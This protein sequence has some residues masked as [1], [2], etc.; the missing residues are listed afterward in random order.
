MKILLFGGR[1]FMGQQFLSVYPDAIA[2]SVDIADAPAV[3]RTLDEVKPDIVI[4]AAGKTGKPNVDWCEDH[5]IETIR[6]NVT[7]PLVLLEECGKRNLYWVHLSSGCVYS[8]DNGGR[9]FTEDDPP[10]FYGSF[11]S[12]TKAW[13]EALLREFPVL[14]LRLRMPFD[15]APHA[16]NL[17]MKLKDYSR[18]LDAEN[19]ITYLP[20]FLK[21]A[22]QLIAKRRTGIYNM[23][24]AG[25]ISPYRIMELYREI[26][27]PAHTF[28]RLSLKDLSGVT[29][30]GRSSCIISPAKLM[31]EG[32]AVRPVEEA[33]REA[34]LALRHS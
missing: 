27:D 5:K 34:L 1:G 7:G 6:S 10:N 3:I 31:K 2:P 28:E 21:A 18:I 11:Y 13:S 15:K 20:D 4:N 16:R 9:G 22:E 25:A 32:I 8:G 33:V 29:K 17:I 12:R 14:I 19:A 26:V 24:N 23:V 30:A